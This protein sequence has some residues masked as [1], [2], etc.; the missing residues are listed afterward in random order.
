MKLGLANVKGARQPCNAEGKMNGGTEKLLLRR[1]TT[2]E[3]VYG[4]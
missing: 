4:W 2:A 1:Y 3:G